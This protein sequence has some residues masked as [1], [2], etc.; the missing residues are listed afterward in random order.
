MFNFRILY[1]IHVA[2]IES[3][4]CAEYYE[5]QQKLIWTTCGWQHVNSCGLPSWSG[6]W[7]YHECAPAQIIEFNIS[8]L[9]IGIGQNESA[10]KN[11]DW[12]MQIYHINFE[13][14][15]QEVDV[16]ACHFMLL[17]YNNMQKTF[18]IIIRYTTFS[19]K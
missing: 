3:Q 18:S 16:Y 12:I 15:I 13:Y 9:C 17:W 10:N 6:Q 5:P 19:W 2:P 4:A 7:L 14:D 8:C 11:L 1:S